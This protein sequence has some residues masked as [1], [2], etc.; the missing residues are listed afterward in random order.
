MTSGT[1][2]A[3]RPAAI[4]RR[5]TAPLRLTETRIR[6]ICDLVRRGVPQQ[7]AAGAV[8]I[9]RRTCQ[10]WVS[11]GRGPDPQP[12]YANLV[13]RLEQALDEFHASRAVI[14]GE[15]SDDRTAIEVLRRRFKDD[16]GDPDRSGVTVN[17]GVI[18]ESPEWVALSQRL[19]ACLVPFP[20]ALAA[21][22]SE[23][24]GNVVD[25]SAVELSEL[26]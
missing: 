16:W 24:G 6:K 3:S 8:G 4:G 5:S 1:S 26:T 13:V 9:P 19:L 2:S 7:A 18:V 25:G 15:S 22:V 17:V 23:L 11:I 10:T 12:L 14:V 21:V 20:E